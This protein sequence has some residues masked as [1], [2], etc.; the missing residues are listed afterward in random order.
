MGNTEVMSALAEL[1][2]KIAFLEAS[3]DEL[4]R[5]LLLQHERLDQTEVVVRELRH[6]IKEHATMIEGLEGPEGEA[7][8]PH[9]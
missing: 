9:Y 1:E 6:R 3:N 7:P 5:A 4:E 8:P 2:T